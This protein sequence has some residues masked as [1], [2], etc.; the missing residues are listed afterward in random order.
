MYKCIIVLCVPQLLSGVH[1]M[2]CLREETVPVPG[3]SGAQSSEALT[4]QQP[5]KEGV[6]SFQFHKAKTRAIQ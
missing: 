5:F 1:K 2:D 4:R 3:L 6:C